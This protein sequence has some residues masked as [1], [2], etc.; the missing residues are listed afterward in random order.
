MR[1]AVI[2]V[3]FAAALGTSTASA[4]T[5]G[6]TESLGKSQGIEYLRAKFPGV[7]SQAAQPANCDG[8]SQIVGGG[9]SMAGPAPKSTLNETYPVQPGSWQAEGNTTGRAR[10]LTAY[11][12]CSGFVPEYESSQSPL[13]ENTVLFAAVSCTPGLDPIAGG[14]GATG[15]GI[16]TIASFPA[17]PPS[18]PL[19][20]R[21]I[22]YNMTQD[23]TLWD[24]YAICSGLDVKHRESDR[25]RVRA[26]DVGKAIARCKPKEAVVSGGWAA[27]QDDVVGFV[28]R[29]LSTRPWDSSEDGNKVPDDGWMVKAQNLHTAA[30]DLVANATCRRPDLRRSGAG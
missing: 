30:V 29:S 25:V 2:A 7:V 15:A 1:S 20:W 27:K 26:D 23:D 14:G 9:G 8:D 24:S 6:L 3:G 22:A 21:P 18:T 17:L 13:G 10:T 11:A 4:G 5:P 28:T 19:G 16:L 12:V